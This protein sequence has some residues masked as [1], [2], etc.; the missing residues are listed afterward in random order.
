[1][2]GL[3][4]LGVLSLAFLPPEHLHTRTHDGHHSDVIHRHYEPHHPTA[5]YRQS[6]GD[7]DDDDHPLWLASSFI[8][9]SP[10]A[11]IHSIDQLLHEDTRVEPSPLTW[12]GS[13]T[14][15]R[16]SIHD[17]PPKTSSGL[18]GPPAF[19]SDLI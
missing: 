8:G 11:Q 7:T 14:R 6:V 16:P 4:A 12:L 10:A 17:P 5:G 1:M 9:A 13:V 2:S 18:R 3:A 15:A 19:L